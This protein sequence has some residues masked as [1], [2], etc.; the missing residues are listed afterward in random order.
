M[1]MS[2]STFFCKS[3]I[4]KRRETWWDSW[5]WDAVFSHLNF[6]YCASTKYLN[7]IPM[8]ETNR[9]CVLA[10]CG[11]SLILYFEKSP[12][13]NCFMRSKSHPVVTCW[14][15]L[16]KQKIRLSF[17]FFFLQY[18]I[19]RAEPDTGGGIHDTLQ[20]NYENILTIDLNKIGDISCY[21]S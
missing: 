19:K 21:K 2:A 17:F 15:L 10:S 16:G 1:S 20:N 8:I 3:V 5:M 9:N 13:N 14:S 4:V 7:T 12:I 18:L 6:L 11:M